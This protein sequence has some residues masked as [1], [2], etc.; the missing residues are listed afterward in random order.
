MNDCFSYST[1]RYLDKP[2]HNL[3]IVPL[4]ENQDYGVCIVNAKKLDPIQEHILFH[5]MIDVSGSMSDV[6][7]RGTGTNGK[8]LRGNLV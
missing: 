5:F 1:I 7:E 3:D 8:Y 4:E 2:Y 6:T